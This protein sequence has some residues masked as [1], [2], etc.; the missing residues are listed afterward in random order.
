ML[1]RIES[2]SVEEV[3]SMIG[4]PLD[5]EEIQSYYRFYRYYPVFGEI[6]Y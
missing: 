1:P 5:N 3:D 2:P 6:T 4:L